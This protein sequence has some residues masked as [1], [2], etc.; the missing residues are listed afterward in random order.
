[1]VGDKKSDIFS[2]PADNPFGNLIVIAHCHGLEYCKREMEDSL[3]FMIDTSNITLNGL[4]AIKGNHKV[5]EGVY[6]TIVLIPKVIVTE[7]YEDAYYEI[8]LDGDLKN[9]L[10]FEKMISTFKFTK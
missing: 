4:S 10:I 9:L 7:P 5:P 2:N 8:R 3:K 1:M 6:K